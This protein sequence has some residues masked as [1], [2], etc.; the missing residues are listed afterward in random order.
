MTN[1]NSIKPR[2][3]NAVLEALTASDKN[4]S[5]ATIYYG[6]SG[7][8][9]EDLRQLAPAWEELA[10]SYRRKIVRNLVEVSE[11]NFELEYGIF[12]RFALGDPDAGV[13]EAAIEVLW[14]DVSMELMY[15][16][17][18]IAETDESREVRAAAT[19]A[20]GRFI[21]GGE[22]GDLPENET[23]K[24]QDAVVEILTNEAEDIDVRRRALE[25]I[26]NSS[27]E[28]VDEAIDAAYNGDES[29]MQISSVFAMGRTADEQWADMII[30]EL[31]SEDSEMRYEAA[32]AAGELLLEEAVNGLSRLAF[33]DDV[34]IQDVAIWSLGEIGGKQAIRV[35]NLLLE[36]ARASKNKE[37]VNAIEDAIASASLAGGDP[38]YLLRPSD[39]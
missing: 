33:E 21:L 8:H 13:R 15:R 30:N 22:M 14:E 9:S 27:H 28:I 35:L 38:L 34:E 20:L 23:V 29:R 7:L 31:D 11:T 12:A 36:D 4:A 10:P 5:D 39:D 17:I 16:L 19:S 24:A 3:F 25:S 1:N 37:L 26:A 2:D 32:R 18:E 6:L